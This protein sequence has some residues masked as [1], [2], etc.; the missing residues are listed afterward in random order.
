M[1]EE[2]RKGYINRLVVKA[3]KPE[4]AYEIEFSFPYGTTADEFETARK[5]ALEAVQGWLNEE[6][7]E[8]VKPSGQTCLSEECFNILKWEPSKGEK[9]GE[10]EVATKI[11][12][13]LEKWSHAFNILKANN[14]TINNHFSREDFLHNYWLYLEKYD[15][16]IFR[17][18]RSQ[19]AK[20]P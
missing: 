19:E 17:K 15:G 6:K 20:K 18:K 8:V 11:S 7:E 5:K 4:L 12:N 9:L 13:L 1:S 3:G 2:K 10:F 16:K 14:A